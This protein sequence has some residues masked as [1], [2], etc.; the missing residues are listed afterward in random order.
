[1]EQ[2]TV[3]SPTDEEQEELDRLMSSAVG[4]VAL[5]AQMISLSARGFSAPEIAQIHDCAEATVYKWIDRFDE[6]GPSGL[7]DREREGRPK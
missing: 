1:M 5:R 6:E 2:K 3:R 7:Y 4:R